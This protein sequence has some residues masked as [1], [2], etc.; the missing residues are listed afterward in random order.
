MMMEHQIFSQQQQTLIS[1]GYSTIVLFDYAKN[2]PLP[3]S[4]ELRAVIE[5]LEGRAIDDD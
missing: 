2:E 3:V 1:E 4:E 5:T